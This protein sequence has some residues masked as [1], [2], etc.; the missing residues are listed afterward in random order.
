[1]SKACYYETL[2]VSRS[3]QHAEIKKAYRG[4]AMKFHPD[5]NPGDEEAEN[6]FKEVSEAYDILKDE[7]KRAAYDQFGHAAFENGGGPRGNGG[8]GGDS[9]ADIFDDLFGDFMGGGRSNRRQSM[10]TR[11]ADLRY[12]M[13]ITLEE[14]FEGKQATINIPTSVS[15]DDCS[16]TG[17]EADSEPEVCGTC[18]GM[19]KVRTQQGFFMVERTCPTCQGSGR[20]IASPCQTCHGQGRRHKERT[21]S[22]KIPPGV[23]DGTRI[24]LGGEGEAG[25]RGGPSGDLYIFLS[26]KPHRI[27]QREGSTIF[28]KV[29]IPMTKAALGGDIE[30]PVI[31][32]NRAKVSV[33]SGT[34]SGRQFRLKGK[35]M[36]VLNS[37]GRKGDMVIE[38]VVETPVNL[39]KKQKELL[40]EFEEEAGED[41]SPESK[42]FFSRVKEVWEDLTD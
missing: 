27:F 16:G 42:G 2:G 41:V 35:G 33:P 23:E 36:T 8:F 24:R 13:E 22:V 7:Q 4:L 40:R 37:G 28:C 31:G 30:V 21:L 11:G 32:G 3:A 17:A 19:G 29:P 15:C 9:F 26:L 14:A 1:M 5:R 25:L 20:I 6:R 12:D 10:K 34:Q 38:T 39:N 18:Q